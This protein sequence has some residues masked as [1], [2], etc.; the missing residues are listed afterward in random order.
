[1][2]QH[3]PFGERGRNFGGKVSSEKQPPLERP[4]DRLT[5]PTGVTILSSLFP[6]PL[7]CARGY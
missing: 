6:H 2:M 4:P 1:M 7:M 5:N 3:E